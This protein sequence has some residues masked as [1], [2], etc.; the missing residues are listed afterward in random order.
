M[1]KLV[2]LD[3]P[4]VGIGRKSFLIWNA[5]G[6]FKTMTDEQHVLLAVNT[7]FYRA[8]E[9]RDLETMSTLWSHG[10]GCSCVHPGRDM[11][12]G[13]EPIR[14]SWEKIFRNTNYLEIEIELIKVEISG[15]LGYVVLTETVLQVAGGRRTK[16]Q[17]I[18]TDLFERMAQQWYLVHHH[19]SPI[20]S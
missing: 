11:L 12:R 10:T 18:A 20:M 17:S 14:A 7:A 6:E 4:K 2:T 19:G 3:S 9:K 16:A 8:F 5:I 13:W 1:P 15:D